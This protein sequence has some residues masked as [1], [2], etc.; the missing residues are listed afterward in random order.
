[1]IFKDLKAG[2][3]VFLFDRATRKFKQGKVMNTPSPDISG[4]KPNMMP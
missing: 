3:P 4:S 1:M 2:F